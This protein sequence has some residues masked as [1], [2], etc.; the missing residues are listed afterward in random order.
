MSTDR[1]KIN[2]GLYLIKSKFGWIISGKAS[3]NGAVSQENTMFVMTYTSSRNLAQLQNFRITEESLP[4]PPDT[5]ELC[6]LE[7]IGI[8]LP[9]DKK[10]E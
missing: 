5:S 1:V 7:T 9:E 3:I 10:K 2:E 6:K 8:S 4:V